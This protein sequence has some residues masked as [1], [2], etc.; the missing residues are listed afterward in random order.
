MTAD[1]LQTKY[2][3]YFGPLHFVAAARPAGALPEYHAVLLL[4]L[5]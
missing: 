1:L 5:S 2:L 3:V 4:H